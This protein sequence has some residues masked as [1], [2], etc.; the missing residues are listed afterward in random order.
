MSTTESS[1]SNFTT[2][3]EKEERDKREMDQIM[4]DN[5]KS[6]MCLEI[7]TSTAPPSPKASP[8]AGRLSPVFS[9]LTLSLASTTINHILNVERWMNR[10]LQQDTT[11]DRSLI[12]KNEITNGKLYQV[13]KVLNS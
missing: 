2:I 6:R 13:Q 10:C 3:T 1:N 8:T 12:A 4:S 11:I 9:R 5:L 7:A